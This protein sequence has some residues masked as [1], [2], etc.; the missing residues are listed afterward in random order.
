[1]LFY[2]SMI[3]SVV[4]IERGP[5]QRSVKSVSKGV[6]HP[7]NF[8]FFYSEEKKNFKLFLWIEYLG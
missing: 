3:F 8:I 2:V 1:L 6:E 5:F 4:I 7:N